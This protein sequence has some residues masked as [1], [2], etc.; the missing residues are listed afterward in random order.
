MKDYITSPVNELSMRDL[1]LR[2]WQDL[3]MQSKIIPEKYVFKL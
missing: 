3:A 2:S 1:Y